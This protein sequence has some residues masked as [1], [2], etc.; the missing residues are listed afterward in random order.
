[1]SPQQ[2]RGGDRQ[3]QPRRSRRPTLTS[4]SAIRDPRR[5]DFAA[6]AT[7]AMAAHGLPCL[8]GTG[9]GGLG[10]YAS[11]S[12]TAG[13]RVA[14]ERP[15]ALTVSRAARLHRCAVCL[16]DSRPKRAS[17][18]RVCNNCHT[19]AYCS[20]QCAA[21]AAECHTNIECE[22]LAAAA[23]DPTIDEDTAD[24]VTQAI[25][26]LTAK[27]SGLERDVGPAGVLSYAA[28]TE[29]LV[30]IT[31]STPAARA[32]LEA[33]CTQAL[34]ALPEP[35]RV[36]RTELYDLLERHSCNLY[37]VTGQAGEDVA[38][39]SFVGLLHLF[40]HSCFPNVLFDS[41]GM[42]RAPPGDAAPPTFSL[43]A[44][45]DVAEGEE[46]CISY[47]SSAEGPTARSD[48]LQEHYG[49]RCSCVRC[50]CEDVTEELAYCEILDALR[51]ASDECGSGL[52]VRCT[53]DNG[54]AALRCV[55][56]GSVWEI[57]DDRCA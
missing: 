33:T 42:C 56:C 27:A 12:I 53:R 16:A 43:V 25:R 54:A 30:G 3:R 14:F 8:V 2:R 11:R 48:H 38:S 36:P 7:E 57:D 40:N 29:R 10:V 50:S 44:L 46:L 18:T 35:A 19:Q 31:P 47:T 21:A 24:T 17:W 52:S 20:E 6:M 34:R 37:G 15:F 1:M 55:H 22:A 49:F 5:A 23:S 26:I 13:E 28:Y 9:G 51:C 39:A 32:D 4:G 41:V 45:S